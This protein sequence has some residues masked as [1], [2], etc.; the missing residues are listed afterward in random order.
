MPEI[1]IRAVK[2]DD[3]TS[4]IELDHSYKTDHMLQMQMNNDEAN[5]GVSFRKVRLPRLSTIQYPRNEED[6]IKSWEHSS[7]IFVGIIRNEFVAYIGMEEI[8][9][10]SVVRVRDIVVAPDYRRLGIASG[11]ILAA[12]KWAAGRKFSMMIMEM[13]PKNNPAISLARKLGYSFSGFQNRYFPNQEM[14]IFFEK[15]IS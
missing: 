11:L 8:P 2:Q 15:Y 4:M 12:E 5:I 3:L 6:L 1:E 10:S 14:A 7:S 13:Q 9:S